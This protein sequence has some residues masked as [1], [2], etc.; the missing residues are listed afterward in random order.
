MIGYKQDHF[1]ADLAAGIENSKEKAM[2]R[3]VL[4]HLGHFLNTSLLI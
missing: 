2:L 3:A 4:G 1:G